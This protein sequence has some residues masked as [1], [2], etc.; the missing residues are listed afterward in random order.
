MKIPSTKALSDALNKANQWLK[1][2]Y[3]GKQIRV[4][5]DEPDDLGGV[6]VIHDYY[7]EYHWTAKSARRFVVFHKANWVSFWLVLCAV[8]T[9]LATIGIYFRTGCD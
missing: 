3:N 5:P 9:T 4:N 8:F 7:S 6:S 2:W 1:D